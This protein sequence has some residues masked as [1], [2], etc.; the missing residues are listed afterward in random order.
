MQLMI[1]LIHVSQMMLCALI[2]SCSKPSPDCFLPFVILEQVDLNFSRL[3]NAFPEVLW[4]FQ[5][6]FWQSLIMPCLQLVVKPLY[7]LCW[8]LLLIVDTSVSWREFFSWLDVVKGF[9]SPWRGFSD[10][11]HCC[12]PW[13]SRSFYVAEL[14]SVHFKP[15]FI[16]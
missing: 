12:P 6:F 8:S 7:L 10:H 14:T 3:K 15:V 11:H 4:L 9:F 16:I 13:M 1:T 5:M 2:M